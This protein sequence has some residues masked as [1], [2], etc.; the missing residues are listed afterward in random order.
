MPRGG[1][2]SRN[3]LVVANLAGSL[4]WVTWGLHSWRIESRGGLMR[5]E[6]GRGGAGCREP[7]LEGR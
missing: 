2:G 1:Q 3:R 7:S 4:Y 5:I 6:G